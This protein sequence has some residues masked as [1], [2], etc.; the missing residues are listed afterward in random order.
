MPKIQG[1][2]KSLVLRPEKVSVRREPGTEE[3]VCC[4][5]PVLMAAG[6]LIG[7]GHEEMNSLALAGYMQRE[8]TSD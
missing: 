4:F 3:V 6:V 5:S 7:S 8:L 1:P 2:P